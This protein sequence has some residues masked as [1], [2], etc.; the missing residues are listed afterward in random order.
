[1]PDLEAARKKYET[2]EDLLSVV[3]MMKALAAANIREYEQAGESLTGYSRGIVLAFQGLLRTYPTGRIEAEPPG[4]ALTGIIVFGSDQGMCGQFNDRIAAYALTVMKGLGTD[5][6]DCRILAVGQRA[7][8]R[9]AGL[10]L[11]AEDTLPVPGSPGAM[12]HAAQD[13]IGV[14]DGWSTGTGVSR[15]LLVYNRHL[16]GPLYEPA[17]QRL[18]PLDQEWLAG[19]KAEPWP[20]RVLP[21]FRMEADGLFSHL[22]KHYLIASI[23][24]AL[25]ESLAS[26]NASRLAAMQGAEKNIRD[27]IVLLKSA[28][29]QERQVSITEELIDIVS[30]FNALEGGEGPDL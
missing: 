18:L 29:N 13:L 5:R 6:K 7:F 2:A 12:A 9:L 21:I 10:G 16:S 1:M 28:Y 15:V 19:I 25:A 22:L 8:D 14:I 20:S 23:Y 17:M 3:K 30:G 24:Q 27:R 11:D 4:R 26:E